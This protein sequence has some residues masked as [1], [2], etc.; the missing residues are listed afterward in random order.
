M[1]H[2]PTHQ[3]P[4]HAP[5]LAPPAA[6]RRGRLAAFCYSRRK[7]VL[8]LWILGLIAIT[9]VGQ[10]LIGAAFSNKFGAGNSE[11]ARAL[12]LLQARFPSASGDSAQIVFHTDTPITDPA[13]E[14]AIQTLVSKLSGMPHVTA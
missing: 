11:S 14:A 2:R 4:P 8:A 6:P 9:V 5:P 7:L 13:N 1:T 10:V 12:K 3:I